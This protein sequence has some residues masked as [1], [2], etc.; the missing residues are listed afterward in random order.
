MAVRGAVGI[1]ME[2]ILEAEKDGNDGV[3]D[4]A[5]YEEAP[6]PAEVESVFVDTVEPRVIEKIEIGD[7]DVV[8]AKDVR[9]EEDVLK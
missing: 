4:K 6:V 3:R 9:S 8:Y 2:V 5:E 1:Y 7:F